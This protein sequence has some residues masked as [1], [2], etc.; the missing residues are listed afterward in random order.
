MVATDAAAL[1]NYKAEIDNLKKQPMTTICPPATPFAVNGACQSCA[2]PT[3]F[4][5][6]ATRTCGACNNFNPTTNLCP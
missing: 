5:I 4:F 2:D 1:N 3:A 6:I